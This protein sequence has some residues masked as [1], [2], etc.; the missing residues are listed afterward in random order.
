MEESRGDYLTRVYFW[1]LGS[2]IGGFD[3]RIPRGWK[4]VMLDGEWV[5][6]ALVGGW[7]LSLCYLFYDRRTSA[8][9]SAFVHAL[10]E[11]N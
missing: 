6:M 1:D 11:S 5:F 9:S 2:G 7:P 8:H 3:V 4:R 10:S